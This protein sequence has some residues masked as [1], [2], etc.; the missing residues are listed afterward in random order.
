M[1]KEKQYTFR[2]RDGRAELH[3]AKPDAQGRARTITCEFPYM[4]LDENGIRRKLSRKQVENMLAAKLG[5][6]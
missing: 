6:N 2:I 5:L 3:A 4:D 1:T